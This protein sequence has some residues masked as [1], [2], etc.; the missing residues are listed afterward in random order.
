MSNYTYATGDLLD[1]RNTYFYTKYEGFPFLQ[2]WQE[3]RQEIIARWEGETSPPQK[4]NKTN[5]NDIIQGLEHGVEVKTFDLFGA[6]YGSLLS[7]DFAM[8]NKTFELINIIVRKFEVTKRIHKTYSKEFK[9]VDKEDYRDLEIYICA[10]EIFVASYSIS[11]NLAYLNVLLKCNDTLCAMEEK[12][13]LR[14]K[15]RLARLLIK[16]R[17]HVS[18]LADSVGVKI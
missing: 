5:I 18:E 6:L 10:A 14:L 8:H 17:S 16:E 11:R 1:E 2:A 15:P 4:I 3:N 7:K 12:L 9:A 13:D